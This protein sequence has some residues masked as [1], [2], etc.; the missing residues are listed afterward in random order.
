LGR[1]NPYKVLQVPE[2]ADLETIEEAYNRLFD[3]YEPRA[4]GGDQAAIDRLE[5]LNEARDLLVDPEQRADLDARLGLAARPSQARTGPAGRAGTSASTQVKPKPRRQ[6][7][8][9]TGLTPSGRTA[10]TSR[11]TAAERP[12][13]A[14]RS[15]ASRRPRSVAPA[16]RRPIVPIVAAA[17]LFVAVAAGLTYLLT[18]GAAPPPDP[19]AG[20]VV[21]TVNGVPIYTREYQERVARDKANALNDPLFSGLVNNFE[22]ITGT[23]MLDVL[24]YDALDKLINMEVIQQEARKEN[25]YPDATTQ[26][27]YIEQARASEVV[28][29]TF[30]QFLSERKITE[31][32]YNRSVIINSVYV[33]M[34][35]RHMPQT[36]SD[37]ERQNA[38]ISWMCQARKNYDVK[39]NLT[40]TVQ[41]E[42]C[43]SGL[44]GDIPLTTGASE[45]GTEVPEPEPS[46]PAALT[47]G[48]APS[49]PSPVPTANP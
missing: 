41:N 23:R 34:A 21:A 15:A 13:Q 1:V 25:I 47:P 38:F 42:P 18:R 29:Q 36:G 16:P 48:G 32:Q 39:I 27:R 6:V 44:P 9:S 17:L 19:G 12:R 45:P 46:A 2:D 49:V 35:S 24:S 26:Q 31:A 10:I 28:G 33:L 40:F 3:R 7:E 43:T 37:D 22:G 4:Y 30:Q 14:P 11:Q 20:A 8:Q 5:V